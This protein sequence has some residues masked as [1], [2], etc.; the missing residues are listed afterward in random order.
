MIALPAAR[1][2]SLWSAE[3]PA[4]QLRRISSRSSSKRS[5]I[6]APYSTEDPGFQ[7]YRGVLPALSD[8]FR[9]DIAQKRSSAPPR[10]PARH[11]EEDRG[12]EDGRHGDR[13]LMLPDADGGDCE[14]GEGVDDE[15][16]QGLPPSL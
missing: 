8:T 7:P 5:I 9:S 4:P 2:S 10:E 16:A 13:P 1:S 14:E 15:P 11:E 6:S 3:S 12:D